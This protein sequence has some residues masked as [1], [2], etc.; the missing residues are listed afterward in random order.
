M[1][2]SLIRFFAC[3]DD[4][5]SGDVARLVLPA[6]LGVAAVR[7]CSL[8]GEYS[9]RWSRW[10]ELGITPMSDRYV[11]LVC[12]PPERWEWA[13]H[14]P[15]TST[16]GSEAAKLELWTAGVRNV[17]LAPGPPPDRKGFPQRLVE[18]AKKYD[19]FVCTAY[20]DFCAWRMFDLEVGLVDL[21]HPFFAERLWP[22][23]LGE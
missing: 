3:T 23:V 7:V 17:L 5:A 16:D 11:N 19:A 22:L 12:A 15:A 10:A 6:L 20:S 14:V 1:S 4:S 8:T 2:A 18:S 9:G 13:V 21:G